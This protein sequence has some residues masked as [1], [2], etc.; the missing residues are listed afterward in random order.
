M[1]VANIYRSIIMLFQLPKSA[2]YS[3][4]SENIYLCIYRPDYNISSCMSLWQEVIC[5]GHIA[6]CVPLK[7]FMMDDSE[8][9]PEDMDFNV[10]EDIAVLPYSSGTTGMPKGVMLTHYNIVSNM[11]QLA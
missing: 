2:K 3:P 5:T 9:Y 6:G 1:I 7:L 10:K 11:L 4:W 8:A